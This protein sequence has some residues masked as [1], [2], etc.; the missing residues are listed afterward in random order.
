MFH[1]SPH[2]N[3]S[4]GDKRGQYLVCFPLIASRYCRNRLNSPPET[5][6]VIRFEPIERGVHLRIQS[7]SVT[8]LDKEIALVRIFHQA[9]GFHFIRPGL[10]F[11]L[12][13]WRAIGLQ[14]DA[15]VF[16]ILRDLNCRFE[17]VGRDAFEAKE[18]IVQWAIEMILAQC[19][20][21]A[22]ATFINGASCDHESGEAFARAVRGLFGKVWGKERNNHNVRF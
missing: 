15:H 6:A 17:L 4:L 21:E 1:S 16:K 3:I 5:L 8:V 19:S 2:H 7:E 11:N 20:R 14:P 9:A 10:D 22:G 18:G 12:G 13:L